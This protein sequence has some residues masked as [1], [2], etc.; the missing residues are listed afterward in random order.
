MTAG[1]MKQSQFTLQAR[2]AQRRAEIFLWSLVHLRKIRAT[3][4][5]VHQ[6]LVIQHQIVSH[7]GNFLE[8]VFLS[9]TLVMLEILSM[10]R[11]ATTALLELLRIFKVRYLLAGSASRHVKVPQNTT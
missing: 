11:F 8:H 5:R 6:P 10:V 2:V 1:M 4:L 7:L 3:Y 9:R